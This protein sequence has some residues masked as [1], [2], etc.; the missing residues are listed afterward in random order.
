MT[1]VDDHR[2]LLT[3]WLYSGPTPDLRRRTHEVLDVLDGPVAECPECGQPVPAHLPAE[4][5]VVG[6]VR[7]R[8]LTAGELGIS[9]GAS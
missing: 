7:V 6:G 3:E 5:V 2:A 4:R 9:G 8:D 1:S